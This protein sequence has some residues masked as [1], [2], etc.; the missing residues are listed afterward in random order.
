TETSSTWAFGIARSPGTTSSGANAM[1][2]QAPSLCGMKRRCVPRCTLGVVVI[3]LFLL[4]SAS[5]LAGGLSPTA[6]PSRSSASPGP[7]TTLRT[8]RLLPR[9]TG[10]TVS[11]LIASAPVPIRLTAA[12]AIAQAAATVSTDA[13]DYHPGDA[14]TVTGTGWQPGETVQLEFTEDPNH[15]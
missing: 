15:D 10:A 5:T 12:R 8:T 14:V 7:T 13:S 2:T 6:K 1:S 4:A 9:I 11:P 3:A